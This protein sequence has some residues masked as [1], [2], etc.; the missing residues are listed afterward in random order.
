[1]LLMGIVC[2]LMGSLPS[3]IWAL[4]ALTLVFA[5]LLVLASVWLYTLVFA[6]SACWYA[7]YALAALARLRQQEA[8]TRVPGPV[9]DLAGSADPSPP[10]ASPTSPASLSPADASPPPPDSPRALPGPP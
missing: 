4:G 1:M 3:L 6:F 9:V 10:P 8:A 7:H 2:G 5:P